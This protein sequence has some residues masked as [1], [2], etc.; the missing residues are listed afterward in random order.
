ME[1]MLYLLIIIYYYVLF[2]LWKLE[3]LSNNYWLNS[4]YHSNYLQKLNKFKNKNSFE[5]R[6]YY[7]NYLF[8]Y[9]D[10]ILLNLNMIIIIKFK[11]KIKKKN[12]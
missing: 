1:F 5:S 10:V 2:L 4:Q 12:V 3:M 11:H 7:H 6:F 8:N 9:Y